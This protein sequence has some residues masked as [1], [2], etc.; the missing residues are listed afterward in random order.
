MIGEILLNYKVIKKIGEGRLGSVYLAEHQKIKNK[1]VA[2]KVFIP[3][4][5]IDIELKSRFI[6][7]AETLS[8]LNHPYIA[9]LVD[10]IEKEDKLIILMEYV[11]G[12]PLDIYIE[13]NGPIQEERAVHIFLKILDAFKYAHSVGIINGDVKPSNIILTEDDIPKIIDFGIAK[14]I[15]ESGSDKKIPSGTMLYMSPEQVTG[16]KIDLRS[17]IY[18]LGVNLF[19]I[20]TGKKP[21]DLNL[22]SEFFIQ[23]KIKKEPLPPLRDFIPNI[24]S[25][26][27]F[28][29]AKATDKNL[30]RRFQNYNEFINALNSY[31]SDLEKNEFRSFISMYSQ[32]SQSTEQ[33]Y[34][35]HLYN[36]A[37]NISN[38]YQQPY[39]PQTKSIPDISEYPYPKTKKSV[40]LGAIIASI[41]VIIFIIAG[42][43][44]FSLVNFDSSNKSKTED[45]A[46]RI[47]KTYDNENENEFK[48]RPK[49]YFCETYDVDKGEIGVSNRFSPGYLTVMVDYRP[50]KKNI[51][52]KNVYIKITKIK[53]EFGYDIKEKSIRTVHFTVEPEWDYIYFFDKKNINFKSAGTYKVYL[54]DK[55]YNYITHGIVEIVK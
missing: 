23:E 24:S 53:D 50:I 8:K 17:D 9:S 16:A 2:V 52:M 5:S 22:S 44:I 39:S 35:T 54:L 46:K 37:K 36:D 26:L 41:A 14:I 49:L 10:F 38:Q 45:E 42:I 47:Q 15:R 48:T 7:E 1:F 32:E 29:I 13:Q 11:Q 6:K 55:N 27:D 51:G 33:K 40:P 4:L 18:S 43:L 12:Y 19:F 34:T 20:L 30:E 3:A 28:I 21:Y 31:K 25:S